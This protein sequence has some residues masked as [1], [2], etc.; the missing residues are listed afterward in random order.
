MVKQ[1]SEEDA[2]N[3]PLVTQE[4]EIN[5]TSMLE[6]NVLAHWWNLNQRRLAKALCYRRTGC[7]LLHYT[8]HTGVSIKIPVNFLLT[9]YRL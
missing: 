7:K 6:G 1:I 5:L 9:C 3:Q 2:L 4:A 8:R